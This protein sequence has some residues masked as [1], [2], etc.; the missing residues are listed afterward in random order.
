[1]LA[2]RSRR[3]AEKL[4]HGEKERLPRHRILE[5]FLHRAIE[6]LEFLERQG[7]VRALEDA[8]PTHRIEGVFGA[9][10]SAALGIHL[11][12]EEGKPGVEERR[13]CRHGAWRC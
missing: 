8:P 2:S 10:S 3:V 5:P 9:L 7:Q 12:E 4:L 13:L 6:P 11:Q 1:M